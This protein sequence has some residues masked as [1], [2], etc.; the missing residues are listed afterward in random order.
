MD[1]LVK[2]YK[3]LSNT[4]I[5]TGGR[6]SKTGMFV[7]TNWTHR[8]VEKGKYVKYSQLNIIND[9]LEGKFSSIPFNTTD[10]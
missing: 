7:N 10:E 5:L 1:K 9:S 8:C 2:L 6:I 3:T 4:P